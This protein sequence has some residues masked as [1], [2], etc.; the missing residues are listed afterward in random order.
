[1]EIGLQDRRSGAD[2]YFLAQN[3]ARDSSSPGK[4]G[5]GAILP[6]KL[7]RGLP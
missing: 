7:R 4:N 2:F 1:M 3:L 5:G 6:A